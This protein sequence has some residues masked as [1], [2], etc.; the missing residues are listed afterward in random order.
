MADS[1]SELEGGEVGSGHT[2]M[3][4]FEITPTYANIAAA[5]NPGREPLAK[6]VVNYRC[7]KDSTKKITSFNVPFEFTEFNEM[8]ACHRFAASVAEFALLLKASPYVKAISW[9]DAI[10]LANES[11]NSNDAVQ[12]EFIAIAEKAKKIYGK[13][14]KRRV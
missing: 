5:D 13:G 6:A 7:P 1:L 2:L 9:M 11:Y 4:M 3:A 8:P 10:L 14:K 12:K